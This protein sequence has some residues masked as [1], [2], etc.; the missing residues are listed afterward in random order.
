MSGQALDSEA[1]LVANVS[2]RVRCE[3]LGYG[4]EVFLVPDD[5]QGMQKVSARESFL[6]CTAHCTA[7]YKNIV[8]D[9]RALVV[10]SKRLHYKVWYN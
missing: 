9:A 6:L 8:E 2:F 10:Q 3:R 4:E 1:G 5:A 7:V